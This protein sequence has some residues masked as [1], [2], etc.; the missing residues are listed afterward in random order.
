MDFFF[1][2]GT[3]SF[4]L[5]AWYL[6]KEIG[7]PGLVL[8]VVGSSIFLLVFGQWM[9]VL[10]GMFI[11]AW[12]GAWIYALR[13]PGTGID[14][15]PKK[16]EVEDVFG[17]DIWE[18]RRK[19][20]GGILLLNVAIFMGLVGLA[21]SYW[22]S[23]EALYAYWALVGGLLAFGAPTFVLQNEVR[24]AREQLTSP[25]LLEGVERRAL[26]IAK[27]RDGM[28]RVGELAMD[29]SLNLEDSREVLEYFETMSIARSQID[30]DGSRVFI[31]DEFR[32]STI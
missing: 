25:Q 6:Y 21:I 13:T 2:C 20:V 28:L 19:H 23:E 10:A 18:A 11:V 29:T 3:A 22:T 9:V 7:L 31:F 27:K 16:D 32:E 24:L 30:G 15:D 1:S 4:L 14:V 26:K 12:T 5:I 8:A 17:R